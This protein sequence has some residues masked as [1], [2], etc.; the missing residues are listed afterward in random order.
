MAAE[1][2]ESLSS[3]VALL[4]AQVENLSLN[5]PPRK[6]RDSW[7]KSKQAQEEST[8]RIFLAEGF[9]VWFVHFVTKRAI[10]NASISLAK[11][12]AAV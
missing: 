7:Q 3:Q 5:R 1:A 10:G 2:S 6:L 4:L 11:L 8:E 12:I 9:P